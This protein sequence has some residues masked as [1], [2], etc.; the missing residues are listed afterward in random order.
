MAQ[1]VMTNEKYYKIK[2][3]HG[4]KECVLFGEDLKPYEI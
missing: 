4:W 2:R 3:T 1:K